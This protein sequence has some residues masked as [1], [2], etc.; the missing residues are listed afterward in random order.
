MADS[1]LEPRVLVVD[2]RTIADSLVAIC[3]LRGFDAV[4]LFSGEE[5][6][7]EALARPPA[8][9]MTDISMQGM[10][11]IEAAIQVAR[12]CPGCRILLVSGHPESG[13]FL[14]KARNDGHGFEVLTK[15]VHPTK[16][17]EWLAGKQPGLK[18]IRDRFSTAAHR[19]PGQP[20]RAA[21]SSKRLKDESESKAAERVPR[22]QTCRPSPL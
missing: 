17:F 10:N 19:K 20:Q 11:G 14:E 6:V 7:E 2:E 15:P 3:R 5:V 22:V 21:P 16:I 9:L 4:S 1:I 8:F 18:T 12:A 13:G